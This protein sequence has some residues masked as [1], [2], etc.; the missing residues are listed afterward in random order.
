MQQMTQVISVICIALILWHYPAHAKKQ[1]SHPLNGTSSF[2]LSENDLEKEKDRVMRGSGI[3]AF[4]VYQ[5][6]EMG[7]GDIILAFPWLHI[8]ALRGNVDAQYNVGYF[9][10]SHSLFRSAF[11]ARY[12]LNKA[13]TQGSSEARLLLNE[14]GPSNDQ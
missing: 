11:L 12:W 5:H 9:Y 3:A 6:Y 4:R 14:M 8:S 1:N 13:S 7:E 10:Y 2:L